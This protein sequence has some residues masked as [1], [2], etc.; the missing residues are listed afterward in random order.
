MHFN[1]STLLGLA[2]GATLLLAGCGMKKIQSFVRLDTDQRTRIEL[3]QETS[4]IELANDGTTT[5]SVTVMDRKKKVLQKMMLDAN[6]R[7]RLDLINAR[8]VQ[9]DNEGAPTV[10]RWTLLNGSTIQYTM[11][12][13]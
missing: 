4:A 1:R 12:N 11:V 10:V 13:P 3:H 8:T 6:E 2:A 7:V 5:I 9:F